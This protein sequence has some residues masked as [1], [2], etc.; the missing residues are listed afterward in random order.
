[1]R[2]VL[3]AV[4]AV[5]VLALPLIFN[6]N[7][8]QQIM[9][10]ALTY[11]I[12]VLGLNFPLGYAGQMS[13]AQAAFWGIGAYT[14]ALLATRLQVN[15]WLGLVAAALVA[16]AFGA[17][18]GIPT[19]KLS[20]HYLA[21]TTIGF[22]IIIG[23]V[24]QN[25]QAL[26][27]ADGIRSIP[28]PAIGPFAFT[29]NQSQYYLLLAFVALLAYATWRITHSRVGRAFLA[30]RE[31][32]LAAAAMGVDV[33]KY[34]I[35]AFMLSA[36]LGGIGGSLYAHTSGYI[37]PDTFSFDQ[38]VLF[39]SML[40]LGGA[41]SLWGPIFGAALFTF[42]PEYLRFLKDSYLLVYGVGVILTMVFFPTGLWGLIER[43]YARLGGKVR[44]IDP[45][46]TA[47][48]TTTATAEPV[49]AASE[50]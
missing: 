32:E 38:S 7:Y 3:I 20:G 44:I 26:G 50:D 12:V 35:I 15:F 34:K 17:V 27:G 14:S 42:L 16:G 11:A 30:V 23:L 40:V 19:L 21:M 24:L 2:F 47:V 25:W 28:A 48:P 49:A 46:A 31:N 1:M 22:G 18:L 33:T 39:L 41:G 5:V 6:S 13:L 10:L 36:A 45:Y 4:G 8:W 29:D 9:V 43:L 37:S